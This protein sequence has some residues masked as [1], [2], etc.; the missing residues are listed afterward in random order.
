MKSYEVSRQFAEWLYEA[1]AELEPFVGLELAPIVE[2]RSSRT[3]FATPPDSITN[4]TSTRVLEIVDLLVSA[5][6]EAGSPTSVGRQCDDLVT[7]NQVHPLTG[8]AKRTLERYVQNGK[9][10]LPDFRGGEGKSQKWYWRTLRPT[11]SKLCH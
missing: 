4:G 10:P 6:A 3:L 2:G 7:L 1:V 8:L 11:L 5:L 9:L